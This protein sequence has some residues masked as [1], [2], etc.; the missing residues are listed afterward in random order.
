MTSPQLQL[1]GKLAETL[2]RSAGARLTGSGSARGFEWFEVSQ[3]GWFASAACA[4]AEGWD[5][6]IDLTVVDWHNSHAAIQNNARYEL[7]L[8]LAQQGQTPRVALKCKLPPDVLTVSSVSPLWAGAA[9][10]EREAFDLYGVRFLGHPDLRRILLYAEFVG[11]PLRK[12]YD[13]QHRQPM[14]RKSS[15]TKPGPGA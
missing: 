14:L 2:S 4:A 11:H 7:V 1:R 6:L 12:D 8:L 5:Q 15:V 13:K 10:L 3:N 9:W